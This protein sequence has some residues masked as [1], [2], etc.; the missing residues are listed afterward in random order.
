MPN[1]LKIWGGRRI[2]GLW[3][4]SRRVAGV[5]EVGLAQI[6]PQNH[7]LG[8]SRVNFGDCNPRDI[9]KFIRR[10]VRLSG[11]GSP[12][13]RSDSFFQALSAAFGLDYGN[14]LT[15]QAEAAKIIN[16]LVKNPKILSEA[17][18]VLPRYEKWTASGAH[19]FMPLALA[20]INM[21]RGKD[22]F[23]GST[24]EELQAADPDFKYL[25]QVYPLYANP[26]G[27]PEKDIPVYRPSLILPAPDPSRT[28]RWLDI[29][30]APKTGGAPTLK[31]L[32]R[33]FEIGLRGVDF[34]IYGTDVT[35]PIFEITPEGEIKHS[36]YYDKQTGWIKSQ[37]DAE[38][39]IYY[40]AALPSY[41]V[42]GEA[43]FPERSF[44]F[45][46]VCMTLHHLKKPNEEL[47]RLPF[48]S[49]NV[50]DPEGKSMG[51]RIE[52]PC[53]PS[54]QKV[55]D[56]LLGKLEVGGILFIDLHCFKPDI[57]YESENQ[58]QNLYDLFF[59]VRKA[60]PGVYVMYDRHPIP[61]RPNLDE[62]SPQREHKFMEGLSTGRGVFYYHKGIKE[63]YPGR[64]E[65]FYKKIESLFDRADI[66]GF[67]YQ[68]FKKGIWGSIY[69]TVKAI[70]AKAS[71]LEIFSIYLENVPPENPLKQ[72]I[73][74]DVQKLLNS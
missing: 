72:S 67:R 65:G 24:I 13:E 30:S 47:E 50:V 38:G 42:M 15:R 44:D 20:V 37:T 5:K 27:V 53:S 2:A 10:A 55:V 68:S 62:F 14:D 41:N 43:F 25:L 8:S 29:G 61:F 60:A 58:F 64:S 26:F 56:R 51:E 69:K 74:A 19:R 63:I 21:F 31:I 35:M 49:L 39:I 48:S 17:L 71:L 46:S 59:M 32:K 40:N 16:L 45:I 18:K 4:F 36:Q 57:K 23:E 1:I 3:D 11:A 22:I 28:F 54:Q 70:R 52:L 73:L 12:F 6:L 9:R 33:A 34:E 7:P 66:L